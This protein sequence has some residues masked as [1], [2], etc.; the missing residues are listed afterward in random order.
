MAVYNKKEKLE[1]ARDNGTEKVSGKVVETEDKN[2]EYIQADLIDHV[3]ENV[4]ID[5][6]T[7]DIEGAEIKALQGAKERISKC[8]PQLAISAYHAIEHLWE[9]PLLIK[10]I[11][12][13]YHIFFRHHRWNMHDTVC[14]AISSNKRG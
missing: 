1:F 5:M 8:K 9:I 12:S 11:N 13:D 14:Y 4:K 6:I 3:L 7:M 10:E 2:D